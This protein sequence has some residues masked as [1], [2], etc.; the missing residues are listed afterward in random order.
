[1]NNM[2]EVDE[3]NLF[4]YSTPMENIIASAA[5]LS[6]IDPAADNTL[7]IPCAKNLLNECILQQREGC[8]SHGRVYSR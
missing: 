1:M 2:R 3:N 8:D 6:N 4:L 5:A 7:E